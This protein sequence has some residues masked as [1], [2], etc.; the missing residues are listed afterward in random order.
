M[1]ALKMKMT[2]RCRQETRGSGNR[3]MIQVSTSAKK[4]CRS[5][6]FTSVDSNSSS[7]KGKGHKASPIEND[8]EMEVENATS[9]IEE[10]S[11]LLLP[12]S[13]G[14]PGPFDPWNPD[15]KFTL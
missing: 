6:R 10:V 7:G 9:D 12:S 5:P 11:S 1:T 15:R 14:S 2:S 3:V 13:P 8:T 4:P